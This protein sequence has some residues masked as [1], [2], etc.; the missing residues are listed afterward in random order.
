MPAVA[1]KRRE[2]A[3]LRLG[4]PSRGAEPSV[5]SGP[6][7]RIALSKGALGLELASVQRLGPLEVT[8]LSLR[9]SSIRFPVDLSGGVRR[10]RHVRGQLLGLRLEL[11]LLEVAR[12]LLRRVRIA[13]P[14][15]DDLTLAASRDGLVVGVA[16]GASALAF[17]LVAA[18][19]EG[20]LRVM[21]EG[22]RGTG[23]PDSAH[24]LA[25]RLVRH[26][27]K[28]WGDDGGSALVLRDPAGSVCRELLPIAG[29]RVPSTKGL[30]IQLGLA[31]DGR[32]GR[33]V[34]RATRDE[35]AQPLS[36]R[37]V[38]A[39]ETAEL[40]MQA[41]DR[42]VAGEL[43]EARRGYLAALERAPRHEAAVVRL[44]QLDAS[45][46][47]R[48][49]AV[50]STLTE[51]FGITDAGLLGV[52]V[53]SALGEMEPAYVAAVKAAN[54][55]PYGRL[56]ASA[57]LRAA[58]LSHDRAARVQ[59]LD[60]AL[61]RA[62]SLAAARWQRAAARL[63]VGDVRGALGD[64]EHIEAAAPSRE[65][66]HAALLRAA[67]MLLERGVA[68]D[69][70]RLFERAL[71]FEPRSPRA[72]RGLSQAL[73]DRGK[74]G[75]A[76]DLLARAVGFAETQRSPEQHDLVLELAEGLA[77]H[78]NDLPG[79]V[80]RAASIPQDVPAG[81]RARLLEARWRLALG[82]TTGAS[83]ALARLRAIGELFAARGADGEPTQRLCDALVEAAHFEDS[84]LSD[85]RSARRALAIALQL[86][87]GH[88]GARRALAALAL[89]EEPAVA[90]VPSAATFEAPPSELEDEPEALEQAVERLTNE[91][92][93]D[94]RNERVAKRLAAVLTRL[95]RDLELLAL[96]SARVE[97][98][99]SEDRPA[100][101]AARR[102]AL[103]RLAA[104]ARAA[105]RV[106]E[107]ELYELMAR[108]DS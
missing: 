87:P 84:A 106:Q 34:I 33:M 85:P 4:D 36:P 71:R 46:G 63:G 23:L 51:L 66:K 38:R 78:A 25:C 2:L 3:S 27:L 80:A 50:L 30:E 57:W 5:D 70:E 67:D 8:E 73:K 90:R 39:L 105:D 92:R 79:A 54:E 95:G 17:D 86:L 7:L 6:A 10:F 9:L 1:R 13:W 37:V 60:A 48:V 93:A 45:A 18:P 42:A 43:E 101:L 64:I 98:A 68:E 21:V 28:G 97:E 77:Q 59:A 69:A 40:L 107:A 96:L 22:A 12:H 108:A 26:V 53:L 19:L 47:D 75:R 32:A 58:E 11:P 94:P 52:D 88:S 44:A 31:D 41:D 99:A 82:D 62:P 15:A 14:E 61:A 100:W 29:A 89:V 103:V 104:A 102:A 56:A 72:V 49:E 81:P 91:L 55:E 65:D 74:F 16:A 20:D 35:P 24:V 76:L 83:R